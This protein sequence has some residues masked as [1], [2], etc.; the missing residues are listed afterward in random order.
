MITAA[1]VNRDWSLATHT[2]IHNAIRVYMKNIPV[3]MKKYG[4]QLNFRL[5]MLHN[6]LIFNAT[7]TLP[8]L[9]DLF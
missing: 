9:D 2:K 3:Q 6:I 4:N 7:T 1:T 5:R 8:I